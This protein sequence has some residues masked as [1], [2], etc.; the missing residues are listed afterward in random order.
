MAKT[1]KT[2]KCDPAKN[3]ECSKTNCHING[4][5]CYLTHNKKYEKKKCKYFDACPSA[6]GWCL[7]RNP[8]E[9]CVSFLLTHIERIRRKNDEH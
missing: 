4:G 2:Y 1:Y 8:G 5:E 7:P 6:T 3:T 9:D